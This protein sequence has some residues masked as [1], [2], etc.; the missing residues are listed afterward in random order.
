[1]NGGVATCQ[2]HH[3]PRC[4]R[5]PASRPSRTAT[6]PGRAATY[7]LH[8]TDGTV[9]GDSTDVVLAAFG[10]AT[11]LVFTNEAFGP[12]VNGVALAPQPAV[13]V[14]DAGGNTVTTAGTITLSVNEVAPS[15]P[16][17]RTRDNY[18][19]HRLV[20][21][22]NITGP[23]GD[24]HIPRHE[25]GTVIGDSGN[26]VLAAFGTATQLV[27]T[28]TPVA[29]VTSTVVFPTQPVATVEDAVGNTVTS[30]ATLV[31]LSIPSGRHPRLHD[32]NRLR[33][34]QRCRDVGGLRTSRADSH[35]HHH[36]R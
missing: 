1:M 25:D 21:G 11:Q 19:R 24:V 5:R 33:T 23:G 35:V 22:C 17:P 12:A 8:A 18:Q 31:F 15:S 9:I 3:E 20:R 34:G 4:R 2:L 26:I 10:D 16:V 32:S 28:T 29:G 36:G 13:T 6:S 30:N 7:T 27:F 14:E